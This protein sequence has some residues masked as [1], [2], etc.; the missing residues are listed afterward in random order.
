MPPKKGKIGK[1]NTFNLCWTDDEVQTFLEYEKSY[2]T[3]KLCEEGTN[4]ERIKEI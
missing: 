1:N 2:K 4:W 3:R